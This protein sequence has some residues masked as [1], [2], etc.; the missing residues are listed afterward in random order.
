MRGS[1]LNELAPTTAKQREP[2]TGTTEV[3]NS[4]YTTAII[5][6]NSAGPVHGWE[7]ITPSTHNKPKFLIEAQAAR[8][9]AWSDY[10]WL[11]DHKPEH[12]AAQNEA[13]DRYEAAERKARACYRAF[14][15]GFDYEPIPF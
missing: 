13:W 2:I 4:Y 14:C 1:T 8:D 9:E 6:G 10:L 7:A 11:I 15:D 12:F 5:G 3:V